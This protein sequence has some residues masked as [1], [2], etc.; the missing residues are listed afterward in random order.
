MRKSAA[1]A[2]ATA[3]IVALAGAGV[4]E[5]AKIKHRGSIVGVPSAKV[6]FQVKKD[7]GELERLVNLRFN[8]IPITCA[9]GSTGSVSAQLPNFPINGKDFTR[10]GAIRG[11]GIQNGT[12]RAA[13]RFRAG[14]K[15]ASGTVRVAFK[16]AG[17]GCGTDDVA[18]RTSSR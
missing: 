3:L 16:T 9:D 6:K 7:R 2:A 13:G 18:W 14:G 15:R 5:A 10:K 8:R 12:L 17:V 4:A 1:A 11:P